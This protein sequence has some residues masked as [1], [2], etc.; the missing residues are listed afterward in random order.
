M[1]PRVTGFLSFSFY[2]GQFCESNNHWKVKL[3]EKVII[4]LRH[5]V[6]HYKVSSLKPGRGLIKF[7]YFTA[8]TKVPGW[9][10]TWQKSQV[11]TQWA[12]RASLVFAQLETGIR[13]IFTGIWKMYFHGSI[14]IFEKKTSPRQVFKLPWNSVWQKF[15]F[16]EE[17]ISIDLE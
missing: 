14:L 10:R 8:I 2:A 6:C 1:G 5:W 4:K 13:T 12:Q 9:D 15:S 7:Q 17:L 16:E 11:E 3:Q